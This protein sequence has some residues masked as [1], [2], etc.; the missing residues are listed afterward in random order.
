VCKLAKPLEMDDF[1]ANESRGGGNELLKFKTMRWD[2]HESD[3]L[4]I[5]VVVFLPYAY[6][7]FVLKQN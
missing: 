2:E 5:V 3:V 4:Q 6:L 1:A 7:N